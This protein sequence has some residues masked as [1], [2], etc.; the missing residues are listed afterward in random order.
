MTLLKN[1]FLSKIL[2]FSLVICRWEVLL[3]GPT[4]HLIFR[5][6]FLFHL[7]MSWSKNGSIFL[8]F[9]VEWISF[10]SLSFGWAFLHWC[11]IVLTWN[12]I[13][14]LWVSM[15]LFC[16][17]HIGVFIL[18]VQNIVALSTD[19]VLS[20]WLLIISLWISLSIFFILCVL[21]VRFLSL[22]SFLIEFSAYP[23]VFQAV[24][25]TNEAASLAAS[26]YSRV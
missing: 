6:G 10:L 16:M 22:F 11:F 21:S 14:F 23:V 20:V 17:F 24:F 3:S 18:K 9:L 19:Q 7:F 25:P 12:L 4:L 13:F 15:M 26:C 1:Y 5:N 8:A 2:W